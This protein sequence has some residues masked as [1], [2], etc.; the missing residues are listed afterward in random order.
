MKGEKI[1]EWITEGF[2]EQPLASPGS[3]K[4]V[5]RIL[6]PESLLLPQDCNDGLGGHNPQVC[7]TATRT[8]SLGTKTTSV[9]CR[10]HR[11]LN[12]VNLTLRK[13]EKILFQIGHFGAFLACSDIIKTLQQRVGWSTV[14]GSLFISF[15]WNF[16]AFSFL[17]FF[18]IFCIYL[19][20]KLMKLIF[21][22]IY[23][24][25]QQIQGRLTNADFK[26][27]Y[28]KIISFFTTSVYFWTK[29]MNWY[30][31]HFS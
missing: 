4:H 1:N 10:I 3:A 14:W 5:T 2:V 13:K 26:V 29:N 24:M 17:A 7:H 18:E 21:L 19:S 6:F 23:R 31:T 8:G 15:Q 12:T 27:L 25:Y 30:K 20:S 9:P 22:F 11:R 28:S 16:S